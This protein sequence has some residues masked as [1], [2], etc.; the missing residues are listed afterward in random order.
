MRKKTIYLIEKTVGSY[1]DRYVSIEGATRN[2]E[3]AEKYIDHM[4]QVYSSLSEIDDFWARYWDPKL[5]EIW[6]SLGKEGDHNDLIDTV[7]MF[8]DFLIQKNQNL[9]LFHF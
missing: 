6:E 2:K 4:N 8:L 7:D 3:R 9:S 5:F 1:E